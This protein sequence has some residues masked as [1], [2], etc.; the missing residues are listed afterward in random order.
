MAVSVI[1]KDLRSALDRL[2]D[3]ADSISYTGKSLFQAAPHSPI[4]SRRQIFNLG[5]SSGSDEVEETDN[6]PLADLLRN[7]NDTRFLHG[8][9]F[10]EPLG[11]LL[12]NLD[13]NR[14]FRKRPI[15]PIELLPDEIYLKIFQHLDVVS[16]VRCLLV[17]N[18]LNQ[19]GN[20]NILWR[21]LY[22]RDMTSWSTFYS[23]KPEAE[24]MFSAS[25]FNSIVKNVNSKLD[26]FL[27][28]G[29]RNLEEV[30]ANAVVVIPEWKMKYKSLYNRNSPQFKL[31]VDTLI[32]KNESPN[33]LS[34]Q[35][36]PNC[37]PVKKDSFVGK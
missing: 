33:C 19:V 24:S 30:E 25:Y 16:L 2:A 12:I 9:L 37:R 28:D 21:I 23:P 27:R 26:D 6:E 13:D 5:T 18:K 15:S 34:N 36:R 3:V 31:R 10:P 14:Y 17:S 32:Q 4:E 22:D 35:R 11:P 8:R 20:D 1:E 29:N 7:L